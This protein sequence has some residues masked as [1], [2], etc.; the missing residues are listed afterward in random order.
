[1]VYLQNFISGKGSFTDIVLIYV[2]HRSISH[3]MEDRFGQTA[4]REMSG[5]AIMGVYGEYDK[6]WVQAGPQTMGLTRATQG[7]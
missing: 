2:S 1:M 5:N 7:P 3:Y 4:G 6:A